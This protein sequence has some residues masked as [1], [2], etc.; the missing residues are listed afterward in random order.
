MTDNYRSKLLEYLSEN[1]SEGQGEQQRQSIINEMTQT[2]KVNEER[3]NRHL[4]EARREG[5]N[6]MLQNR[7]IYAQYKEMRNRLEDIDPANRTQL[8]PEPSREQFVATLSEKEQEYEHQMNQL[9]ERLRQQSIELTSRQ[10]KSVEAAET[11]RKMLKGVEKQNADLSGDNKLLKQQ[12]EHLEK[13]LE[14]MA[15]SGGGGGGSDASTTRALKQLKSLQE[16][17]MQQMSDLR[18]TGLP[19]T[20]VASG[21]GGGADPVQLANARE[22]ARKARA[23]AK[24]LELKLMEANR[25]LQQQGNA[26]G[27][28]AA[29]SNS[30]GG[31]GDAAELITLRAQVEQER[32]Q[33]TIDS[34]KKQII[35]AQGANVAAGKYSDDPNK[36]AAELMTRNAVI[37]EELKNYQAYMKNAQMKFTKTVKKLK[38]HLSFWK[39]KAVAAGVSP[40]LKP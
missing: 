23:E 32:L 9:R 13:E 8:P 17:L 30:G 19:T 11:F 34:L 21:A 31:G 12:K 2:Y 26:S 24:D 28:G 27:G 16:N 10:E 38:T 40:D 33:A 35:V 3:M 22:D 4:E 25:K 6:L 5:H 1:R 7:A 37:E 14:L 15:S 18:R 36:R 20:G 29:V 39:K